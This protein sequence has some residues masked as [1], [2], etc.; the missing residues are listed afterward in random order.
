MP[1]QL[2][3]VDY[4]VVSAADAKDLSKR[5]TELLENGYVP[6]GDLKF[7]TAS[8]GANQYAQAVVMLAAVNVDMP[9]AHPGGGLF[10]PQ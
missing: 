4:I 5:V 1:V 6:H 8:S 10:I 7:N 3:P 2:R 9:Q